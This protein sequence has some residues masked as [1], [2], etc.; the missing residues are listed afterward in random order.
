MLKKI[1]ILLVFTVW[2]VP[3]FAQVDTALVRRYTGPGNLGDPAANIDTNNAKVPQSGIPAKAGERRLL[4]VENPRGRSPAPYG[5]GLS[6]KDF[7][8]PDGRFDLKAIRAS[9]YQGSLDLRGLDVLT[10]PRTGEPV[11]SP[12]NAK[13]AGDPDDIFWTD[14]FSCVA[15]LDGECCALCVYD[16]NLIA[17]GVFEVANCIL[18]TNI[19]SWNGSSWSPLESGM[20]IDVNALAVYDNKLIAGG[21]FT[22]A[23]GV[24]ANRIASWN[25]SSWSPLG[26]GMND[27]VNALAVYDNKLIA[28][29]Y[30]TTAGGVS[31]NYIASWGGSSWSPLGSG[32]NHEVWALAIYYNKLIA[33]GVFDYAGDVSA[34]FI[35][36]WDGSSWSPL[37]EGMNRT[38]YALTVYDNKLI[39]GGQFTRTWYPLCVGVSYIASWDGSYWSPLGS[40][41]GGGVYPYVRALAVYDNKLIAG[42]GFTTAAG[43]VSANHIVSWDGSSWSPLG[44]GMNYNVNALAVYDNKLIVGGE[45]TTAGGVSANNIASWDGSSWSTLGSGMN[46]YY[47]LALAVYDNKL[48]AGGQFWIAGDVSANNIASW[49]G[50]SWSA[51]GSGTGGEY[52]KVEAL[53]VYDNK[54][55][56]GG[57]FTTAGG[58][59]AN[60]IASWDGSSW[61]S[62]GSGMV[63]G[64]YSCVCALAVYD[65]KLIV[66]G[67]FTTAGGV[68]ANYIASWDGSSWSPLGSGMNSHV[69]AL[70]VYDNKLIAGG[71]FT[72]AGSVS[73]NYIASW[74]GSSWSALGSGMGGG[75]RL[76]LA[77]AVYDNRLIAGGGFTTAG[78]KVSAGIAQWTKH[79]QWEYQIASLDPDPNPD[80]SQIMQGGEVYRYYVVKDSSGNP[81]AGAEVQVSIASNTY[82]FYSTEGG[83]VSIH[84]QADALSPTPGPIA[85]KITMINGE[86]IYPCTLPIE[87]I[88]RKYE[89]RKRFEAQAKSGLLKNTGVVAEKAAGWAL[90]GTRSDPDTS[91]WHRFGEIAGTFGVGADI[92]VAFQVDEWDAG[93]YGGVGIEV[94]AGMFKEDNYQFSYPP[95]G[96]WYS[97]APVVVLI[98]PASSVPFTP[99]LGPIIEWLIDN[100]TGIP[101]ILDEGYYAGDRGVDIWGGGGASGV[102]D[103][104]L[105][106]NNPIPS[107]ELSGEV[108]GSLHSKLFATD[109]PIESYAGVGF[110]LFGE[111]AASGECDFNFSPPQPWSEAYDAPVWLGIL[112]QDY[113]ITY[114]GTLSFKIELLTDGADNYRI[115][116]EIMMSPW[117]TSDVESHRLVISGDESLV[118]VVL[119]TCTNSSQHLFTMLTS[120]NPASIVLTPIEAANVLF[121]FFNTL[122]AMQE[123]GENIKVQYEKYSTDLIDSYPL[124][125]DLGLV[126][127]SFGFDG[128]CYTEKNILLERGE[129]VAGNSYR[130]EKYTD[131][132]Y[133]DVVADVEAVPQALFDNFIESII[134]II[135]SFFEYIIPGKGSIF[136]M[137][138]SYLDIPTGALPEGTWIGAYN[139]NWWGSSSMA[140]AS[141]LSEKEFRFR[142]RVMERMQQIY[143]LRYGVGGF[144]HLVPDSLDMA[145]PATFTFAYPDSD[146]VGIDESTLSMYWWDDSLKNWIHVGGVVNTDSNWVRA[147]ITKFGEYT[148]APKMPHY[149]FNLIPDP[150]TLPANGIDTCQVTSDIIH[151]NDGTPVEDG[152]LF[153]ISTTGGDIITEDADTILEG[154][155]VSSSAG[156]IAFDIRAPQVGWIAKVYAQ[157][158]VG[159]AFGWTRIWFLDSLPPVQPT[160]LAA[161]RVDTNAVLVIWNANQE[162]DILGYLIYYDLDTLPP[163]DGTSP[164]DAVSPISVGLDTSRAVHLAYLPDTVYWFAVSCVDMSGNEGDLSSPVRFFM[165]GDAN[166][167]GVINAADVVYL[168]NYLFISGPAPD[169][170]AAGDVNCNGTI[171]AADVVYLINYLFISGPP[172]GC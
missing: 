14:K 2:A 54:L 142:K 11:L 45:F 138:E 66:G 46:G 92:G 53:A 119:N 70:A 109:Y 121:G 144:Y 113:N 33:G 28:G 95:Q 57:R 128:G 31:A 133:T 67:Y 101:A 158:V 151:N 171:N 16:G 165:R 96:L 47:V 155:Q 74:D 168:I 135:F 153:T 64:Y 136:Q 162:E 115:V 79:E 43:G 65:N 130:L 127:V 29:G 157:S 152:M 39:A 106:P 87:I 122:G 146:V 63:G 5:A 156:T 19:A 52:P 163:W 7:L 26:S 83:I 143:G 145:I 50:S 88:D 131:D 24:G 132:S 32:M 82:T 86:P 107:V 62:L 49:D 61:D 72:T 59:S 103:W 148:L 84:F 170:L 17:G 97:A 134:D 15:G 71:Q 167:D 9:G 23:G 69:F 44:S 159:E 126:I 94:G 68:S 40:G 22:T 8:T 98:D 117:E 112:D 77:L 116:V 149:Q 160:G 81:I 137:G 80:V 41:M 140:K 129:W 42:G 12:G 166:A 93:E 124:S 154:I 141:E 60:S 20:N 147:Q 110:E 48:I 120:G 172:P 21:W 4:P 169:P 108:N 75:Y 73:A 10:D 104:D 118:E 76:V 3:A 30:F 114:D 91:L 1:L 58:V 125:L 78:G 150:D 123:N 90:Y 100:F 102:L 35:A 36:S 27:N 37:G 55:I 13:I 56:A 161:E 89:R 6:A 105:L 18:A 51:L 111:A 139:W 85:G 34:L 25:G 38:V 99:I 164:Y